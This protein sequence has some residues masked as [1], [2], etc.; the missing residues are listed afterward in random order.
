MKTTMPDHSHHPA[1]FRDPSGFVF[2]VDGV[3]YRQVNRGFAADYEW[4]I[5]SGLYGALTEKKLLIPHRE[6]ADDLIG[7]PGWYKTL[8]P[9]QLGLITYPYEWVFDQLRDA[10]LHTLAVLELAIG[11]GLILKDASPFNIQFR[12]GRPI[13]IDTLSFEKYDASTP[14]IAY[15]QFCESFLF[16]LYLE[17]YCGIGT[18]KVLMAYPDGV[19]ATV[20]ARLLPVKSRLNM[21]AWMHVYL[22]NMVGARYKGQ[23]EEQRKQQEGQ[24]KEQ[25]SFS[26]QKLLYLIQNLTG[27]IKGLRSKGTA[28]STW[29]NYYAETI[30]SRQ[31]LEEK[32]TIFRQFIARVPFQSAL[33]IGSND[34]HFSHILSSEIA[35]IKNGAGEKCWVLAIDGDASCVNTLYHTIREKNSNIL[36]L[37]IDIIN[38]TPAIGFRNA[39][40]SSFHERVRTGLVV[41]LALIH[42]LVLGRNVPLSDIPGLLAEL[43]TGY[44][45]IEFIP[46]G[47]EKAQELVRSKSRFHL[48]YDIPYF[49]DCFGTHF[50][51]EE[52]QVIRG[53]ERVLYL[54]KK[55]H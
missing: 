49:E 11:H 38:P 31:Y 36:P 50:T 55:I 34:G 16:P 6:I 24:R 22:Q 46:I 30:L 45:I 13:F 14:W 18:H 39:E 25:G 29:S 23:R 48:P 43:T 9:E 27:I 35:G 12:E 2:C 44:L 52:K 17:H 42:H 4:L 40:R 8:L 21:G 15:L 19:P 54:M 1:S 47:D 28:D 37:C 3:Y 51:I 32:E 26:K 10:A 7:L 41:A 53:T 33:D 5:G 20:T